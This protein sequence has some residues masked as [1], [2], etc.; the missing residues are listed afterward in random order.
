MVFGAEAGGDSC[1]CLR[2]ASRTTRPR[3]MDAIIT[4]PIVLD[5][6]VVLPDVLATTKALYLTEEMPH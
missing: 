6:S 5:G 4:L 2:N 1:M 3:P